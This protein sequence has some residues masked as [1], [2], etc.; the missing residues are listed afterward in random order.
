MPAAP[1]VAPKLEGETEVITDKNY[2]LDNHLVIG[3]FGGY[4]SITLPMGNVEGLPVG[5]NLTCAAKEDA[6]T[7][8]IAYHIES[9]TGLKGQVKG[10]N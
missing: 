6:K 3:N 2:A 1:G 7:L 9:V 10:G 4:P 8:N 5:I